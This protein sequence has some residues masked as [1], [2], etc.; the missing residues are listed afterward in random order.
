MKSAS[1]VVSYC[2]HA[3]PPDSWGFWSWGIGKALPETIGNATIVY[4]KDLYGPKVTNF[5]VVKGEFD[6]AY[7]QQP[8]VPNKRP[9]PFVYSLHSDYYPRQLKPWIKKVRP[10]F[11]GMLQNCPDELVTFGKKVGCRIELFPWFV[12]KKLPYAGKK[13]VNGFISGAVNPAYPMRM[14]MYEFLKKLGRN[15]VVLSCGPFD[16]YPLTYEQYVETLLRSKYYFSGGILDQFIPPK[17]FEVCNAGACLVSP[18]LP[19]MEECGFVDGETYIRL[20]SL[21]QIQDILESDSW[22]EIGRRGRQMV[23]RKHMVENRAQRI[24]RLC[25]EKI[26]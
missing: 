18:K 3:R 5:P 25:K 16:K 7:V 13:N 1:K 20:T 19:R 24:L 10:N 9:A 17:Y 21:A 8:M 15:D 14:R 26:L 12:L 2:G 23:Q 11:V 6:I 22:K 4:L